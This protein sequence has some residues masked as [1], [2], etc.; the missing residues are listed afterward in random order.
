MK[1]L[2]SKR[3]LIWVILITGVICCIDFYGIFLLRSFGLLAR[4]VS[5]KDLSSVETESFNPESCEELAKNFKGDD[6]RELLKGVMNSVSIVASNPPG[7]TIDFYHHA[8]QGGG[9]NCYGM[10]KIFYSVL[11]LNNIKSRI[12]SMVRNLPDMRDSHT[13]VEVFIQD[14]W[15]IFD[16]TFNVS[17]EKDGRM[18][19]AQEIHNALFD[20][21]HNQIKPVFYGEVIY[22]ARLG[23]YY[24]HWLLLFNNVFVEIIPHGKLTKIPP[25][26]YWM[27]PVHYLKQAPHRNYSKRVKFYNTCNFLFVVVLPVILFIN[28]GLLSIVSLSQIRLKGLCNRAGA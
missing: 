14:K 9:L 12:V 4:W 10:S 17:F 2:K 8:K 23:K 18:I 1:M 6:P 24:M 25:F 28:F 26:R 16:P 13:T 20:G 7:D 19:G 11:R 21:S 22:P 15:V 27:G 5:V 3:F